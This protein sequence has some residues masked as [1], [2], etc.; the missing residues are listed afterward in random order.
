RPNPQGATVSLPFTVPDEYTS[1]AV[2]GLLHG[3][4]SMLIDGANTDLKVSKVEF[5]QEGESV[6]TADLPVDPENL[7]QRLD[8]R[9][10]RHWQRFRLPLPSKIEAGPA[11]LRFIAGED[12][13]HGLD[14]Y[15]IRD[16]T[17]ELRGSGRPALPTPRG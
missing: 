6:G 13:D 4:N 3:S 5:W 10:I 17:I 15:E 14:D 2:S 7:L 8:Y 9:Q 12:G 11:E 1:I 16:V